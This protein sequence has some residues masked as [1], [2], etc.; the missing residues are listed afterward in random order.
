M[1][2]FNF[3]VT[4]LGI[5]VAFLTHVIIFTTYIAKL[6]SRVSSLEHDTKI[7]HETDKTHTL[8]LKTL[9]KIEA[10]IELLITHIIP[11]K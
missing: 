1:L 2:D 4:L 5:A 7:L 11:S 6:S 9:S 3:W 10:Q 8:E